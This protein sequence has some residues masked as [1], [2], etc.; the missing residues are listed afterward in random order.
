M[1]V[2][3]LT[4]LFIVFTAIFFFS[5]SS[6]G[7]GEGPDPADEITSIVLSS[8]KTNLEEGQRVV[9][10][11]KANT[12]KDVTSQSEIKV[13]GSVIS[14][15][16]Y[17]PPS[18][19][20]YLVK[21]TYK[22]LTSNE[23]SITATVAP[24]IA[25]VELTVSSSSIAVGDASEFTLT[26][27]L[28]DGSTADL[29]NNAN[30]TFHIDGTA[31][32]GN[33]NVGFAT[34]SFVVKGTYKTFTSSEITVQVTAAS[35]SSPASFA[36]KA[37]IE[38]YTGTWCGW[39]PRVAYAIE[40]VEAQT[41]KV[42]AVAAHIGD[43][44]ENTYST[45]LNSSFAVTSYPTAYVNR[46]AKWIYPEPSNVSQATNQAQ[47]TAT[48]GLSINSMLQGNTLNVIIGSGFAQVNNDV[49]MVVFVLEDGIV[50]SQSNYTSYFGGANPVSNF[51]HNHV[52]RHAATDV[53]GDVTDGSVGVHQTIFNI[54]LPSSIANKDNIGV[55]V[56][57]V[58]GTGK[59]VYNAQ[60]A[61]VNVDKDFD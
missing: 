25:S 13:N 22:S 55:L 29:T 39:C 11:V 2:I 12:Q 41:D 54:S 38:D 58:D 5:C 42:F 59:V 10:V 18:G 44:M 48:N 6:P 46:S 57:L 52:L 28:T 60:Y 23:L 4:S 31:I 50:A 45:S 26:G 7:G 43:N 33:R 1:K 16:S 36:K 32:D 24:V 34:G 56:M 20:N 61:H 9:F 49:K 14:G 40:Q 37:V 21:A 30:S 17:I 8:D 27:T 47:G 15:N 53:L 35:T 3:K 19:G 51:E